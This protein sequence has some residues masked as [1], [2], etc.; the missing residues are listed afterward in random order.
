VVNLCV[1]RCSREEMRQ[2]WAAASL[3]TS[4]QHRACA[5]R[6]LHVSGSAEACRRAALALAVAKADA[7]TGKLGHAAARAHTNCLERLRAL[8]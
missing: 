4:A 3:L 1:V 5:L 6:V 7:A 2:V 8:T